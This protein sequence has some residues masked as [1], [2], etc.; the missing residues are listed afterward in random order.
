MTEL[1]PTTLARVWEYEGDETHPLDS[2]FRSDQQRL[3]NGNTLITESDGGRILEGTPQKDIV[4]EFVNPVRGGEGDSLIL[5]VDSGTRFGWDEL[6]PD[7][8]SR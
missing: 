4:W 8:V 6:D 1:N 2:E 7:F 5:I 3:P